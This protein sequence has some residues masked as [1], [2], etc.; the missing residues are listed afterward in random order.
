MTRSGQ[1]ARFLLDN[2][3][4]VSAIKDPAR[5]TATLRLIL[6]MIQDEGVGLVGRTEAFFNPIAHAQR[7]NE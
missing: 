6:K 4:F 7:R 3:V 2:N 5:E 1:G